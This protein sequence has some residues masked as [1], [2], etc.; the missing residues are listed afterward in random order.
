M[1]KLF[2]DDTNTRTKFSNADCKNYDL[3]CVVFFF[4]AKDN[5]DFQDKH[6]LLSCLLRGQS[7]K[8]EHYERFLG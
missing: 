7:T 1:L 8:R 4:D 3:T 6:F 5:D 2:N